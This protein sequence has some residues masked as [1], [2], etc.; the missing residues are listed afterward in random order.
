MDNTKPTRRNWLFS[1]A[2]VGLAANLLTADLVSADEN[3]ITAD[4]LKILRSCESL[5]AAL[6]YYGDQDKPFYQFT[7][8]LGD[9]AAG[10][11][12]NPFDRVTKLD[13]D[14]MLTFIDALAKDGFI[15]AA[16]DISTK[17]IKPTVGYNLTLTAKKTGGAADFKRL[18]WQAIK[19]DGHVE[20]Y[21][22]LGWDLKMIERLESWQPALN[23]AAA[24]D[25]EF[26][27]GRLSGLK[28]EWQKKP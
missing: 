8:H 4:R 25:M 6:R 22:A 1:C 13:R 18:G 23:G 20:L 14:A 10:A 3:E 12:N 28:R 7:F 24:K 16:R 17:D 27:L 9:F 15:A 26:V 2:A 11:D 19:G 21:Q 5:T